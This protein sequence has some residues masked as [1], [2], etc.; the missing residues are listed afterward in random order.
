MKISTRLQLSSMMFFEYFIQGAWYVTM[1]TFLSKNLHCD[2]SQVGSAYAFSALAFIIS[3]FFTGLIADKFFDS[4][5]I[6]GVLHILGAILLYFMSQSTDFDT[7]FAL[8]VVYMLLY[9]PTISLT[10][11][12][13]IQQIANPEKDFPSI[14]VLGTIGWI[15]SGLFLGKVLN[16][17]EASAMPFFVAAVASLGFGL[18]AFSLP[19]TPPKGKDAKTDLKS[20]LG[21]DAIS[22]LKDKAF[23]TLLLSIFLIYIPITFY[24][25]FGS[26]FL[27]ELGMKNAVSTQTL[28]QVSEIGFMLAMPFFLARLGLKYMILV[29]MAAWIVRYVLFAYANMDANIFMIYGGI[30]LH[31]VCYDFLFVSTQIYL[32]KKAPA[33]LRSSAQALMTSATYGLGMFLGATIAGMVG[34]NF[35]NMDNTHTWNPIWLAAAAGAAAILVG[36]ALLFRDEKAKKA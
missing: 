8:L 31:G 1:G 21:L 23:A 36:F 35:T 29:G 9:A 7:F 18:Y 20:L 6:L 22:M 11:S 2:D 34:K 32:D 25:Q 30:A 15:A 12:V 33:H 17:D 4:E 3:P 10:S 26:M 5:K 24:F 28:G 14:R 16:V 13:A 27:N 19:K